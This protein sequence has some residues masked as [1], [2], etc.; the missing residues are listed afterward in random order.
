MRKVWSKNRE[1]IHVF[2]L[3]VALHL[4]RGR[5]GAGIGDLADRALLSHLDKVDMPRP[6]VHT[7]YDMF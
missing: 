6:H 1:L 4:S 3:S 5:L 7:A 2:A